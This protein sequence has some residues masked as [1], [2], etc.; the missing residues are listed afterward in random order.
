MP[1]LT[2]FYLTLCSTDLA[3]RATRIMNNSVN[4]S[5]VPTKYYEFA[6]IFS[7]TKAETLV[8]HCLYNLQIKLKNREKLLIGTIYLLLTTKQKALKEFISKNLNT[9]FI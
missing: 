4:L 2:T 5:A 9:G 8:L 3:K 1:Q 7:K 6:N